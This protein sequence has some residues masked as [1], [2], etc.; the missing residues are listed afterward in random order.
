MNIINKIQIGSKVFFSKFEDYNSKDNDWFVLVEDFIKEKDSMRCKI[1]DDDLIMYR[2]NITKKEMLEECKLV[3]LKIGKFLVPE[4]IEHY[5]VT[6][7][8][9]KTL[10][11]LCDKLDDAHKYEKIIIEAYIQNNKFELSEE[12]LSLAYEEYKKYRI[13]GLTI[14]K[15][16]EVGS[17]PFFKDFEDYETR[18]Y[19]YVV[20]VKGLGKKFKKRFGIENKDYIAYNNNVT[21]EQ[22]I[23]FVKESKIIN[24]LCMF[25]VPEFIDYFK[26]TIEDLRQFVEISENLDKFHKYLKMILDAYIENNSFVLTNEQLNDAYIEYKKERELL[27]NDTILK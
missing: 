9:L 11:Y 13:N 26:V 5:K 7:K 15:N 18:D 23:R 12:Q 17:R 6:I 27:N 3:P 24:K 16:F 21:K 4:F 25:L 19:D 2:K 20:L 14:I 1:K 8:D 22:L 10:V